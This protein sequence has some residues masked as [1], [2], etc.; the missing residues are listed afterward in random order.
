MRTWKATVLGTVVLGSAACSGGDNPST[1]EPPGTETPFAVARAAGVERDVGSVDADALQAEAAGSNRFAVDMYQRLVEEGSNLFFSPHSMRSALGMAAAGARGQTEQQ[2]RQALEA[3]PEGGGF[4]AAL[5]RLGLDLEEHVHDADGVQLNVV[6]SVWGQDGWDFQSSYL[7][8]LARSYGA[9]INLL[10]F[11][12]EPDACRQTINRWVSEQTRERIQDLL[13]PGSITPMSRLVLT[14]AV[15]FLANWLYEFDPELTEEA[16]FHRLDNSTVSAPLMQLGEPGS[17]VEIEYA[18]DAEAAVRAVNLYYRGERLCM[19]V[20]LPD[21]GHFAAYEDELSMEALE[22]L[23]GQLHPTDLPPLRLPRFTYTSASLSL[24]EPLQAMG[25][26]DAFDPAAADFSGI[27]GRRD[28]F[29]SQVLHKA[30]VAVDEAGTEAAAATAVVMETTSAPM[31]P[32]RFIA[33][34][35]FIF[36]IRDTQTGLILFMGRIVDP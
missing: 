34:R 22:K 4:H 14:N 30:F 1:S 2:M 6:N 21:A 32:P 20:V 23:I 7:D 19:T 12:S 16:P 11:A 9:G 8:L 10:D 28:L 25:M 3:C 35:P 33:D 31:D 27:D 26:R 15:Y 17:K 29:I 18:R 24:N 36:L 13:P 5:N